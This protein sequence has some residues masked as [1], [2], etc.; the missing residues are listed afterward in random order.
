MGGGVVSLEAASE[1]NNSNRYGHL[2]IRLLFDGSPY[3]QCLTYLHIRSREAEKLIVFQVVKNFP[4]FYGTRI[5]I[6]AFTSARQLSISWTRLIQSIAPHPTSWRSILILSS[7]LRLALPNGL[8]P[9]RFPT[10]TLFT[11][12]P[13]LTH[14]T[15]PTHL[16]NTLRRLTRNLN[17]ALE[18][19]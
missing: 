14:A 11:P 17:R 8:F 10:K 4:T 9:S 15:C 6:T 5:F 16:M 1:V 19:I 12:L 3:G 13:S 2:N 18:L 7:H